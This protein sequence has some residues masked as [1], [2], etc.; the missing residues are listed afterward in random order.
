MA[1]TAAGMLGLLGGLIAVG[2]ITVLR[3]F[4]GTTDERIEMLE[5][6]LPGVN[7]GACGTAGCGDMAQAMASGD[8]DPGGCPLAN[9]ATVKAI[10]QL[11]QVDAEE[12]KRQVA[13]LICRGK[14][15][16]APPRADYIG[17]KDCIAAQS[18]AG[19]TKGCT[20]GC[21]GYGTCVGVCPVDAIKMGADGL[22]EIDVKR[23]TGCGLC[24]TTCP[25][26]TLHLIEETQAAVIRCMSQ[27]S[28][29]TVRGVCEVGCIQCKICIRLCP[30][31]AISLKDG[32][33]QIDPE[34]C[35]GCGIC[36][37]KC[38]NGVIDVHLKE[39]FKRAPV[40]A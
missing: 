4:Q 7:C 8:R 26:G 21:L 12:R 32:R 35:D 18:V 25:R 30:Q 6:M 38:P 3:R 2:L 10:E 33:I 5:H 1:Y 15:S 37:E 19:G 17:I 22:P 24:V 14:A 27:A 20:Y 13:Q 23:C 36:A 16:V 9:E 29:K 40:S 34:L 39:I 28:G 11:L 31:N